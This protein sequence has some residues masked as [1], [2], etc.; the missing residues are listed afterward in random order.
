MG[1]RLLSGHIY[2]LECGHTYS[3]TCT[4]WSW[5]L[6]PCRLSAAPWPTRTCH[7]RCAYI[8]AYV[9][10]RQHTSAF[11]ALAHENVP[12]VT[13]TY[14][15]G[16]YTCIYIHKDRDRDRDRDSDR[17]RESQSQ[18]QPQQRQRMKTNRHADTATARQT[19][20]HADTKR[21]T[22]RERDRHRRCVRSRAGGRSRNQ[23]G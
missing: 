20:I 16:I 11:G 18:R 3:S 14:M 13:C 17:D 7:L 6:E 1:G 22:D 9:S 5:A 8:S 21:Q 10:I 23:R 19:R 2:S 12:P 15:S 4:C